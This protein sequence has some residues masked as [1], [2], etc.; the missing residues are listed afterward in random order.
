MEDDIVVAVP[1]NVV[2]VAA[3]VDIKPYDIESITDRIMSCFDFS[4]SSIPVLLW[5]VCSDASELSLIVMLLC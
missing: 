1:V 5:I 3:I 2:D 4:S